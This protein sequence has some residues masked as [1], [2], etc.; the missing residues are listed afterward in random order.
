MQ[1]PGHRAGV[2]AA[3]RGALLGGQTALPG[4]LPR[5]IDVETSEGFHRFT[6]RP[7]PQN[8]AG[9]TNWSS[10]VELSSPVAR[11]QLKRADRVA[12]VGRPTR[13]VCGRAA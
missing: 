8:D 11:R 1:L 3:G 6:L 7:N 4:N 12:Y 13:E 10:G 5:A 2:F 9:V